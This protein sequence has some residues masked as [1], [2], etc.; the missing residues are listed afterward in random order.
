[1]SS[2]F[3]QIQWVVLLYIIW[4]NL[5]TEIFVVAHIK[6]MYTF[7]NKND[8]WWC[9]WAASYL[10]A[11]EMKWH[12]VLIGLN[13]Y[14]RHWLH[15]EEWQCASGGESRCYSRMSAAGDADGFVINLQ[16]DGAGK[17]ALQTLS[18]LQ[19]GLGMGMRL[20]ELGSRHKI[21]EH[22]HHERWMPP[23]SCL[24]LQN[25]LLL[26]LFFFL[27]CVYHQCAVDLHNPV[28][29]KPS[30]GEKQKSNGV[31]QRICSLT[32]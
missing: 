12:I 31:T 7:K 9:L 1:M 3:W 22:R 20:S 21:A 10:C 11:T 16:A 4:Y 17:L 32:I 2:W 25:E 5:W 23:L 28:C 19:L 29:F 24:L 18:M 14:W 8:G 27:C 6:K 30:L 13:W 15:K 26:L